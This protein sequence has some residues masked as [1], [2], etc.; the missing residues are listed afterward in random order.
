MEMNIFEYH[1]PQ[2]EPKIHVDGT[3]TSEWRLEEKSHH[4]ML[5]HQKQSKL[6]TILRLWNSAK[7]VFFCCL[8]LFNGS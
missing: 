3:W 8:S 7:Y 5:N 4:Q 1:I 6:F 2:T